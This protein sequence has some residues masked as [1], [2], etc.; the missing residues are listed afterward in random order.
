MTITSDNPA[1]PKKPANTETTTAVTPLSLNAKKN[2]T[3]NIQ[4]I[5][6]NNLQAPLLEAALALYP[7]PKAFSPELPALQEAYRV[8]QGEVKK[9][10][11]EPIRLYIASK[12]AELFKAIEEEASET[13]SALLLFLAGQL[14]IKVTTERLVE[15]AIQE[16]KV[17]W[18]IMEGDQ[19]IYDRAAAKNHS[20]DFSKVKC[21]RLTW[22]QF[23]QFKD[24][25]KRG[26]TVAVT[27]EKLVEYFKDEFQAQAAI[28]WQELCDKGIIN[29]KFRLSVGWRIASNKNI[30]LI[31]LSSGENIINKSEVT[32]ILK[33]LAGKNRTQS[34][35]KLRFINAWPEHKKIRA[36][37]IWEELRR[38]NTINNQNILIYRGPAITNF[39]KTLHLT[40]QDIADALYQITTDPEYTEKLSKYL[41]GATIYRPEVNE[42]SWHASGLVENSNSDT[43]SQQTKEWHV[44]TYSDLCAHRN[45]ADEQTSYAGSILNYDHIPSSSVVSQKAKDFQKI[46]SKK[47]KELKHQAQE[48]KTE[49]EE[50]TKS[51]KKQTT[52]PSTRSHDDTILQD[53]T[54]IQLRSILQTTLTEIKKREKELNAI[55]NDLKGHGNNFWTMAILENLHR[56]GETYMQSAKSQNQSTEHPFIRDITCYIKA[57]KTAQLGS[58]IVFLGAAR[59]LFKCQKSPPQLLNNE[60]G[61]SLIPQCFFQDPTNNAAIDRML[62]TG[63]QNCMT[64]HEG[65]HPAIRPSVV[66][67]FDF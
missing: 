41:P 47:I 67:K 20:F 44:S 48:C 33:N 63:L 16:G 34:I 56:Q 24:S 22:E 57:L 30:K 32:D 6:K 13:N 17:Y 1:T 38:I 29:C 5:K 7:F 66:K 25:G 10:L 28:V 64:T 54:L 35:P 39:L 49:I 55:E 65:I 36:G 26:G 45:S 53:P 51:I 62:I 46:I 18:R 42:K 8:T 12:G 11:V 27:K 31:S 23:R 4:K 61:T 59:Y 40:H 50:R 21:C 52:S 9:A 58:N 37:L 43:T 2:I 14:N 15:V 60:Y 3:T 19:V